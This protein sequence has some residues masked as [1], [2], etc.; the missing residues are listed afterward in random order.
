MLL[1]LLFLLVAGVTG[2][3]KQTRR[4]A[5]RTVPSSGEEIGLASW[6]GHPYHGRKTANGETY[7]MYSMTAAHR[8]L[9]FNTWVRVVNLENNLTTVVRI[10]D[11]GPFIEGRIIDLSKKAAEEIQMVGSGIALVRLDIIEGPGVAE[12]PA[13][14]SVQVGAFLVPDNAEKLQRKLSRKFSGVFV[15]IHEKPDGLYYRVRV[16]RHSTIQ[17]AEAVAARLRRQREV[18]HAVVVRLN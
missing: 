1:A 17:G 14:Y 6:Y 18:T 9:A 4:P 12:N 15:D 3:R 5:P 13:L 2:C 7:D 10:N 11:R 8:T 16:G